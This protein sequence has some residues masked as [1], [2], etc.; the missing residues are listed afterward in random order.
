LD[1]VGP[2]EVTSIEE[3][4]RTG[5]QPVGRVEEPRE[6]RVVLSGSGGGDD[7]GGDDAAVVFIVAE[8]DD[9]DRLCGY[10]SADAA[11]LHG[12]ARPA[13]E[14]LGRTSTPV[15]ELVPQLDGEEF[16]QTTDEP[17][18]VEEALGGLEGWTRAWQFE[19][20]GT[21][22]V[23]A[24]R[25][26]SDHAARRH[27]ER[28]I[29]EVLTNTVETFEVRGAEGAVGTRLL[30]DARLWLQPASVGPYMDRVVVLMDDTAVVIDVGGIPTDGDHGTA[31]FVT[32]WILALAGV[33]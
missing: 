4:P 22:R 27:A 24:A 32:T 19:E 15:Q 31:T 29:L 1:A 8:Q 5:R 18:Q 6:L 17:F 13:L 33:G 21:V 2:I 25:F 16:E 14:D 7:G 20:H 3:I 12:S 11:E 23:T 9:E 10:G 30:G 28:K 26:S